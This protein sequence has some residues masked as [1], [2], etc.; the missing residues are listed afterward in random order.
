MA[1]LTGLAIASGLAGLGSTLYNLWANKRDADYQKSLQQEV[2]EREDTAVQRRM[3]DLENA[4]LN[5][6]LA[7]GSAAGAGSVVARSN[8]NDIDPGSALDMLSAVNNLKMQK[9]QIENAKLE[10]EILSRKSNMDSRA[11]II[12]EMQTLHQ[13]GFE[14]S[15]FINDKGRISYYYDDVR[16]NSNLLFNNL[17][18]QNQYMQNSAALLQKQNDWYTT[19]MISDMVFDS[20]NAGL[21]ILKPNFYKGGRK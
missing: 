5:P 10:G 3:Q 13:L 4:G 21:G 6:N 14:V 15:P 2:F 7:A 20:I 9:Q 18:Y 11:D 12:D 1:V 16:K 8:T 19:R 17:D